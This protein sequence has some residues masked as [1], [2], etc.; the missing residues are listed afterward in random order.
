MIQIPVFFHQGQ[1]CESG[2]R[3]FV[4][5]SIYDEFVGRMLEKVKK[6]IV[7]GDTMDYET[8]MGPVVSKS[9]YNTWIWPPREKLSSGLTISSTIRENT[10]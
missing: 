10:T 3:C 9:Q 1:V 4:P 2:T 7:L 6:G 8:T 5:E